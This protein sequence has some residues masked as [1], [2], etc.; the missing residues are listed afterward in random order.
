[1]GRAGRQRVA[2]HF[3]TER[4]IDRLE[5]LYREVLGEG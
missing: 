3:S 4:R 5:A 2:E 1:M